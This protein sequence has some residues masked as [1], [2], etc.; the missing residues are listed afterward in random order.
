MKHIPQA[1]GQKLPCPSLGKRFLFGLYP[2]RKRARCFHGQLMINFRWW[3]CLH[4]ASDLF[5][6]IYDI[7]TLVK[8]LLTIF[9]IC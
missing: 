4:K 9:V 8:L 7:E 3:E 1:L 6:R 2:W 5:L